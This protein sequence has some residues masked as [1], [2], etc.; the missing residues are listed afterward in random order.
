MLFTGYCVENTFARD[1]LNGL[2]EFSDDQGATSKVKMSVE[3]ISF[4]A[5]ADFD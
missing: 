4:S 2:R 5:H 1:I 3:Y